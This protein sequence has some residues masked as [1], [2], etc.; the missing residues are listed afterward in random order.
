MEIL[1]IR[2]LSFTYPK[3]SKKALSDVSLSI[4]EGDFVLICGASGS[5]KTT[6]LELIKKEISPSGERSGQ[7]YY[8]GTPIDEIDARQSASEIGFVGQNPDSQIVTDKVWHE[9][10]F[11]LENLGTPQQ[12]IRRRTAETASYFG[13]NNWYRQDTSSLSGGQKQLLN[14]ASAMVMQPKILI[15]DEPTGQL[16]PIVA[17]E[18]IA[19]LK[20]LNSELG[21]TIILTEHRLENAFPIADKIAVM[22]NGS[23]IAFD[24]PRRIGESMK[25]NIISE[26][27]PAAVR[28]FQGL[29]IKSNCPL[30]IKESRDFLSA[31]FSACP[32]KEIDDEY[33]NFEDIALETKDLW[34]RYEKNS[35]DILRGVTFEVH[36][37]EIFTILGSTGAGKTTLLNVLSGLKRPYKGGVKIFDKKIKE[38]KSNTLYKNNLALLPQNPVVVFTKDTVR[39]DYEYLLKLFGCTKE[40]TEQQIAEISE[41]LRITELLDKHPYDLSGGEQQKCAIGKILLSHPKILLLD[42]PTKGIDAYAKK[43]LISILNELKSVGTATLIVTH[44][45]EFAAQISDKCALFFDGEII[46]ADTPHK[47]FADNNYYTTAAYRIS[48]N[49]F[50][51]AILCN[52]IIKFC[53]EQNND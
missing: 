43:E 34:F 33:E 41:R 51:N 18:F 27:F 13:I 24:T 21:T 10:A 7:I 19:T 44:D 23:V 9:L 47:F 25:D 40:S 52:D 3:S 39:E 45:I 37:G 5:G 6:L 20:K 2:D 50:K 30:T 16:D 42:E 14:L 12:T 15:L 53:K 29:N 26:G 46:S 38:Y 28:I 35:A 48:R 49:Q 22:E 1:H 4:N 36:K 17:E 8:Y 32:D 31:H 11:G